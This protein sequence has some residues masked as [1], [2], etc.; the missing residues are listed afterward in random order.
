MDLPDKQ[1]D[2]IYA[3]PPWS[4]APMGLKE[5]EVK[6]RGYFERGASF[7]YDTMTNDDIKAMPVKDIAKKNALLWMWVCQPT[8]PVAIE[9]MEAWGF[10][11]VTIGFIWIKSTSTSAGVKHGMGWYTLSGAELCL[12]GKRG[13]GI[14]RRI[15]NIKQVQRHNTLAHSQKPRRFQQDLTSMY[16][17]NDKIELFARQTMKSWDVWGNESDK[18]TTHEEDYLIF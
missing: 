3:D 5:D 15:N 9:V 16:P 13:N 2:I 14:K 8:L 7:H 4:F 11:Y 10:N 18:L 6:K 12:V 1:Y 17:D